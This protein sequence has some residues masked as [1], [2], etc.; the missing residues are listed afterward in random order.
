MK[1]LNDIAY[2][3]N[4]ACKLDMYLPEQT[5][6]QTIV[7]FHGGG[8]ENG[9]KYSQ[10]TAEIAESFVKNGY[11]FISVG[12]RLY[13]QGARYPD[14][15]TDCANAVAFVKEHV[16]EYGGNGKILIS[17]Q[18]AGAWM[19]L[20]LCLD[21]KFLK[22]VG[23]EPL[24]IAGWIIDSAQTTAHFNVL[25]Y[26]KKE[27]PNAQRIDEFAPLY[28]VS[29]NTKFTKMLLLFYE[30][31]MPC[32]PEQNELFY[33]AILNFDKTAD[34][35]YVQLPG[36]HCYGSTCKEEDGEYRFV[37]ETLRWLK[38]KGL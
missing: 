28:Y 16:Q 24:S 34:I 38:A 6:F 35:E 22:A 7:W 9:N 29:E 5:G 21:G 26:E 18:S 25:K 8:L 2:K 30:Q 36:T 37:K 27:N 31:D 13:T 20:M 33:K 3:N 4:S 1:I 32:R 10:A 14:Y 12:Y 17:G 15:L 11:G 19:A 23:I